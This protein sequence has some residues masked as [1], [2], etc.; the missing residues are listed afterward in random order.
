MV[1]AA[2]LQGLV[3]VLALGVGVEAQT[4]PK[5]VKTKPCTIAAVSRP[6]TQLARWQPWPE[7]QR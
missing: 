5:A 7:S 3:L 2:A 4:P 6:V 1:C